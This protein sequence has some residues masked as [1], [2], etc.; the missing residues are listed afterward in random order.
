MRGELLPSKSERQGEIIVRNDNVI[1]EKSQKKF[2]FRNS[3]KILVN[4]TLLF[5]N[6]KKAPTFA[7]KEYPFFTN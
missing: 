4:E 6:S 3:G 7:R 2:N 1:F 5:R